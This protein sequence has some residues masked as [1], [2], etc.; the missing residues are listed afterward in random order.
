MNVSCVSFSSLS[1]AQEIRNGTHSRRE[2]HYPMCELGVKGMRPSRPH[3]VCVHYGLPRAD[4]GM[5][6]RR[7]G[8]GGKGEDWS[9]RD[10]WNLKTHRYLVRRINVRS[11]RYQ[12]PGTCGTYLAF[13]SDH[14][15]CNQR[16]DN[17]SFFIL[18][19][20]VQL[21]QQTG[22]KKNGPKANEHR[23]LEVLMVSCLRVHNMIHQA[24][25]VA[26]A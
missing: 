6:T 15:T 19:L 14:A 7:R 25:S 11:T 21:V 3:H 24:T 22:E 8:Q 20:A 16:G 12:L 23:E 13:F 10:V 17:T 9:Q 2:R 18:K 5:H 4:R 26:A 1:H